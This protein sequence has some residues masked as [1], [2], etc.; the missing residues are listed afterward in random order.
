MGAVPP[1]SDLLG[2]KLVAMLLAAREIRRV[3]ARRYA[4]KEALISGRALT[5]RLALI[6]TQSALGRSSIYN[7]VRYHDQLLLRRLG[8]T[9]GYG[10][11]HFS[12]GLYTALSD[13]AARY[14]EATAKAAAWGSGFRN[15]REVIKKSLVS[16]GLPTDWV[17]HGIRREVY[18]VPL[19]V[20]TTA[21]LRGEVS[22][23]VWLDLSAADLAEFWRERWL[24]PRAR[25]RDH[26]RAFHREDYAL[27]R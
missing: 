15:R 20:K 22:R 7:R 25:Q 17:H 19:A 6:T 10:E 24:L 14:C 1:Y 5:G 2:G 12:N 3:F 13:Y 26:Y 16:L 4:D 18:A 9:A 8:F 23:P 27:W 21:F 11:F